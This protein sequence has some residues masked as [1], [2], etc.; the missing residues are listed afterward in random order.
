MTKL[1]KTRL[2]DGS[3]TMQDGTTAWLSN[4]GYYF[5]RREKCSCCKKNF[6]DAITYYD[7]EG[8]QIPLAKAKCKKCGEVIESKRCGD[9]VA[10]T[11]G[12]SFVDTDRWFPERHRYG[13][14]AKEMIN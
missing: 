13:G 7:L 6:L 5:I 2:Q 3:N 14:G 1:V 4:S 9:F 12:E 11:C 10:C 8:K